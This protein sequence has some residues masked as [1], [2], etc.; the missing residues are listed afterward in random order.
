[1]KKLA[2]TFLIMFFMFNAHGR[3][4]EQEKLELQ[5]LVQLRQEKFG[6]YSRAAAAQT[7]IFGNKTKND[8]RKQLDVMAEI[9]KTDNHIITTL[10]NFLD[11]RTFQRTEMSYSQ[12]ELDAKNQRLDELT[13]ILSK[14]LKDSEATKKSVSLK[15]RWA[16]LFNYLL[17]AAVAG[18]GYLVWKVKRNYK[19][20]PLL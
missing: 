20:T 4:R 14:K 13:T 6:A 12:A 16:K 18:M 3:D 8:L 1:M 7:G 11:Y 2:T 19:I 17:L 15:L 9:I 10:D 5:K